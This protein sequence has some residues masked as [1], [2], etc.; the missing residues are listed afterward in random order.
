MTETAAQAYA[1]I[2]KGNRDRQKKFYDAN[3]ARILQKKKDDRKE[4]K[5]LRAKFAA[6]AVAPTAAA[7]APCNECAA[8]AVPAAA[9]ARSTR[10][11]KGAKAAP[12]PAPQ[13][14]QEKFDLPTV[15]A[16]VQQLVADKEMDKGYISSTKT[17]FA[18]TQCDTLTSCLLKFDEIENKLENGLK[19]DGTPYS[20]NS[21]KAFAQCIV[22]LITILN[23][24]ISEALKQKYV[25]LMQEY[26]IKS[27]EQTEARQENPEYAVMPYT[28]Y[29]D[30]INQVFPANSKQR[31][32]AS[33]Y[34]EVTCRDNYGGIQIIKSV[35]EVDKASKQNYIVVPKSNKQKCTVII[36]SYKTEKRY[37]TINEKVSAELSKQI[38]QY[39]TANDLTYG[40]A[41]FDK[42]KLSD[43]I[44]DMNRK[45]GINI[46]QGGVNYIRQSKISEMLDKQVLSEKGRLELAIKMRHSPISQLKYVRQVNW[47]DYN[48][49]KHNDE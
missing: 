35:S 48:F 29:K 30:K 16:K 21:K 44:C 45:I 31:L 47:K 28:E 2:L 4:L 33:L 11:K 40:K 10:G 22:K 42:D 18:T 9:P 12:A 43:F 14:P 26:G 41:L 5:E 27:K 32:L 24:P 17:L 6:V 39:M 7:P 13:P 49:N 37:G 23:I 34:D 25:V 46:G 1:R 20:L 19:K 3:Q 8:A 36:Q 15:L 38:R